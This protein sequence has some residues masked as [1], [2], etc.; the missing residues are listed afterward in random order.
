MHLL[1]KDFLKIQENLVQLLRPC[2]NI[3]FYTLPSVRVLSQ[4]LKN[5]SI[6]LLALYTSREFPD[7][8][9]KYYFSIITKRIAV[10]IFSR[11]NTFDKMLGA[12]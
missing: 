11:K 9:Y 7:S 6:Q 3:C 8:I 10:G 5:E 4:H 12:S 1:I 2:F